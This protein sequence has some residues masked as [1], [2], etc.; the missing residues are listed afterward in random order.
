MPTQNHT[1]EVKE[2]IYKGFEEVSRT[3][4]KQKDYN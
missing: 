4:R 2:M 1:C 3:I